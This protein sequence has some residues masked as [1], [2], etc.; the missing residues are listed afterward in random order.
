[1]NL[2]PEEDVQIGIRTRLVSVF[3]NTTQVVANQDVSDFNNL[4]ERI[5]DN[6]PDDT[7][8]PFMRFG[9]H[10]IETDDFECIDNAE[11]VLRI[12]VYSDDGGKQQVKSITRLIRKALHEYP[13]ELSDNGLSNLY[14]RDTTYSLEPDGRRC[15]A[16]IQITADVEDLTI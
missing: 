16:I 2:S 15:Q 6:V 4:N 13:M 5:F 8:F 12:H 7:D 11:H 9:E 10:R 14:V 3:N 1:M